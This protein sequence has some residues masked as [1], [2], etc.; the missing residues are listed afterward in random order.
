MDLLQPVDEYLG[1]L[2]L[3]RPG[4]LGV[5]PQH[6]LTT[7]IVSLFNSASTTSTSSSPSWDTFRLV[8]VLNS[9]TKNG[10]RVV[11]SDASTTCP[12]MTMAV[13]FPLLV[14]FLSLIMSQSRTLCLC[15]FPSLAIPTFIHP[16]VTFCFEQ[17]PSHSKTN[18]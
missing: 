11:K 13:S 9:H 17:G 10:G 15:R 14:L 6:P 7:T 8:V 4:I 12:P 3:G 2:G 1:D 5:A 16:L 18:S